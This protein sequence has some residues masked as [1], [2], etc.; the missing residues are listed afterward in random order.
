M[1]KSVGLS[2]T[3]RIDWLDAV[4]S[5]C[6]KNLTPA[7]I[8][9]Q[10]DNLLVTAQ[11]GSV[12]RQRIIDTLIKIWVRAEPELQKQGLDL[13]QQLTSREERLWLHYGIILAQYPFFRICM[14][15][16]GQVARTYEVVTRPMIKSK[17]TAEMGNLGSIERAIERLFKTLLDWE[18]LIPINNEKQF[19]IPTRTIPT[20]NKELEMWVL[21]C[22]LRSHPSDAV[23]FEDLKRLPE[24]FPF[25]FSVLVDE[26][27]KNPTFDVVLQG[28]GLDMVKLV[29]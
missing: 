24:L 21:S 17:V 18:V 19:Q 1:R 12:E 3:V 2:R 23:P 14:A 22:A 29:K 25:R 5:M 7:E 15:A 26:L 27:R 8:R 13:Y 20:S 11:S 10:L 9:E 16:I 6:L 4:A 28:G